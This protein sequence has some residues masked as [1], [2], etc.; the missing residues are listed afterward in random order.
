MCDAGTDVGYLKATIANRHHTYITMALIVS[1][2][3]TILILV[4]ILSNNAGIVI[5]DDFLFGKCEPGKETCRDCYIAL[6]MSLF[7]GDGN[8][9]NLSQAF[10]PPTIDTP[11]SVI[12]EY[13]FK[14]ETMHSTEH[15]F[16]AT[17]GLYFFY[18]MKILQFISL[19]FGKPTPLYERKV[20]VT[21]NASEC[22]G[23]SIDY[24][25]MLTQ[26]VSLRLAY[27]LIHVYVWY[28]LALQLTTLM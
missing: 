1:C 27:A 23:V 21:L 8:M 10:F 17:S 7:E 2:R 12:V 6:V 28:I 18:P 19:L 22:F 26:R 5:A 4:S 3:V 11:D 25:T 16:W 14:N 15:W 20:V 9:F 13:H 24:M